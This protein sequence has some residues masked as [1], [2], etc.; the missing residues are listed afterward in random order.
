MPRASESRAAR[1]S[2]AG[3]GLWG[4]DGVMGR[5]PGGIRPALYQPARRRRDNEGMDARGGSGQGSKGGK[6]SGTSKAKQGSRE[7]GGKVE[8]G[9]AS[10]LRELYALPPGEFTAARK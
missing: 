4:A 5:F 2:T 6:G 8:S 7:R 10:D 1:R 3:A 9:I